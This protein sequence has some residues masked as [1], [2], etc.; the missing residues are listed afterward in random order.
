MT[1]SDVDKTQGWSDGGAGAQEVVGAREHAGACMLST[2]PEKSIAWISG[3]DFS[4]VHVGFCITVRFDTNCLVFR[5][6]SLDTL[7]LATVVMIV[8]PRTAACGWRHTLTLSE[9]GRYFLLGRGSTRMLGSGEIF[10]RWFLSS[11]LAPYLFLF[12]ISPFQANNLIRLYHPEGIC[13]GCCLQPD[14][15]G[16]KKLNS[17]MSTPFAD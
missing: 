17:S 5:A 6:S 1:E 13:L 11:A 8:V 16:C 7:V 15:S 4:L 12:A 2:V 10:Y 3:I 14:G 9:K